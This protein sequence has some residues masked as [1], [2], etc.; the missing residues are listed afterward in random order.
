[1]LELIKTSW[2]VNVG[3]LF[4]FLG[5]MFFKNSHLYNQIGNV[6]FNDLL[7]MVDANI[8]IKLAFTIPILL[9]YYAICATK[10]NHFYQYLMYPFTALYL[11]L[12]W[13]IEVRYYFIPM[14]LF[15]YFYKNKSDKLEVMTTVYFIVI[16]LL[17]FSTLVVNPY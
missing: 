11:M 15:I 13:L 7:M 2:K 10:F 3:A 8:W 16:A 4:I 1:M 14:I 17:W 5:V 9:S 12:S 6:W